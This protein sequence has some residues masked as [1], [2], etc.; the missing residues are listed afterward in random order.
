MKKATGALS[1]GSATHAA[2]RAADILSIFRNEEKLDS[3]QIIERI[4]ETLKTYGEVNPDVTSNDL[5]EL[6]AVS[7]KLFTVF[8]EQDSARTASLLNELFKE[9]AQTPR[10]SQ[11]DN[12]AWHIHVDSD[13]H[14]SWA[15]WFATSSTF[16]LAILFAEKQ[17]SPGGLCRSAVCG[18]PFIDLGKGGGRRFCSPRCASRERVGAYRTRNRS[19]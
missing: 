8:E 4:N 5:D 6:R 10:L 2:R 15:E 11:H 7:R 9:Y 19:S 13:D 18:R 17:R 1:L 14:T 3:R 16:A 12:T